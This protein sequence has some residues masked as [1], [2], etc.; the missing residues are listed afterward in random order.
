M[1]VNRFDKRLNYPSSMTL[2]AIRIRYSCVIIRYRHNE[3][4]SYRRCPMVVGR[5]NEWGKA[6]RSEFAA[7]T[8]R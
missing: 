5:F 6:T 8:Q 4:H 3:R 1:V 7:R 2:R